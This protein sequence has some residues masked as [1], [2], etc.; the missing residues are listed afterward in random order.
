MCQLQGVYISRRRR[1]PD[2]IY[3]PPGS[4]S[5]HQHREGLLDNHKDCYLQHMFFQSCSS[6]V[7]LTKHHSTFRTGSSHSHLNM[8]GTQ[9]HTSLLGG[10][11]DQGKMSSWGT[12]VVPRSFRRTPHHAHRLLGVSQRQMTALPARGEEGERKSWRG[13]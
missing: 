7:F 3:R 13:G 8:Q 4:R 9:R 6:R 2:N 12:G 11:E 1:C 5:F 10:R